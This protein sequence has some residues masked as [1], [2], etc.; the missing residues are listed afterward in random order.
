LNKLASASASLAS[1]AFFSSS[2]QPP[3]IF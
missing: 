1:R 2:E 3:D